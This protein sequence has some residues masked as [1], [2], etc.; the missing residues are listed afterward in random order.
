LNPRPSSQAEVVSNLVSDLA[1]DVGNNPMFLDVISAEVV[2][3]GTSL[4]FS[5][6]V[7]GEI[8]S[9]SDFVAF[10]WFITTGVTSIDRPIIVLIFDPGVG[11]WVASV[12]EGRPPNPSTTDLAYTIEGNVVTVSVSSETLGNPQ[13]LTWHVVTRSSPFGIMVPLIDRA[14]D[15]GEATWPPR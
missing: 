9:P 7:S 11:D 5:A 15:F 8:E 10:G 12:F 2:R 4:L 1:A 14:P 13:N 6:T 3:S